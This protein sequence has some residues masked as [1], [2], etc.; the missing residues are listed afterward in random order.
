MKKISSV[1]LNNFIRNC[2]EYEGRQFY[3]CVKYCFEHQEYIKNVC[4]KVKEEYYNTLKRISEG[5]IR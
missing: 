3:T 5:K 2:P 1:E 4:K